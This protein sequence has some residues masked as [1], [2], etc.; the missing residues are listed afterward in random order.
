MYFGRNQGGELMKRILIN[1]KRVICLSLLV[2][3]IFS[4]CAVGYSAYYSEEL[5]KG[6]S[7]SILRLHVVA[8]SDSDEDQALKREIRDDILA[9]MKDNLDKKSDLQESKEFVSAHLSDIEQIALKKINEKGFNYGVK[10][11]VGNFSFPTKVYGDIALPAGNYEALRVVL[12]NGSGANWWCVLF[13]PLCFVDA[14]HGQVPDSVKQDLKDVLT[15]EEYNIITTADREEDIPIQVKFKI[16][17]VI[18]DSK[19]QF[20]GLIKRLFK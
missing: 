3:L 6:L 17:E 2:V 5:T 10:A 15:T 14:T 12:G 19:I 16:V 1:N 7:E 9:Y 4:F 20:T 18:E 13:P 8:N 11:M